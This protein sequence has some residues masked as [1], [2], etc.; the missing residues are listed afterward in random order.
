MGLGD[1]FRKV[2]ISLHTAFGL[3]DLEFSRLHLYEECLFKTFRT[4]TPRT[5]AIST[6]PS[7]QVQTRFVKKSKLYRKC[8]PDL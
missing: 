3:A 6:T 7:Q 8:P 4:E 5:N 1:T 2:L